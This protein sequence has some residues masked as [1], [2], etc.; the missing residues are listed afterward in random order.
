MRKKHYLL[1]LTI[2]FSALFVIGCNNSNEEKANTNTK[3]T[4][5]TKTQILFNGSSTLAPVITTIATGFSETYGTWNKVDSSLPDAQIAIY[6]AA[7][8]SGQG[9]KA[10]IEETT[11][12]GMLAREVKN[13][14]KEQI[15]DP[16][17]YLVGIDALTLA[18]HPENPL[19]SIKDDLTKEEIVK[20]FSGEYATW[21]DF[22]ASLPAEKIVVVTRDIGGGAHEVFQTKIMGDVDVKAD[23]IQEASMGA[24]VTKVMENKY[25]IGYAS[26]GVA[27]QNK[28]KITMLKVDGI[29]ANIDNIK[30]GSYVIQRPLLLLTSGKLAAEEQAFLDV[31]LGEEGQ[32]LV[33]EMGFISAK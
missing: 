8:G 14:E 27:N 31:I 21:K 16:V 22:D 11:D 24:L 12:L 10:V 13:E 29:E 9:A 6:V 3:D 28:G 4:E 7:G 33:E 26:F 19:L 18:V 5:E 17:E 30:D 1:I 25:A 32:K 15:T 2:I 20:I 23:A